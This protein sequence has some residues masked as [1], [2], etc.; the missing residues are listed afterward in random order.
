D[1]VRS[2][3]ELRKRVMFAIFDPGASE[4]FKGDRDLTTWQ[5]DAVMKVL[6]EDA[7]LTPEEAWQEL[8]ETPDITS[9]EEYPD[10]ALITIEQLADYMRR[11][12]ASEG[13]AE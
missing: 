10:H 13:S 5:T 1:R 8:C 4:G 12:A 7:G 6:Q 11:A 3:F 9:P 2:P